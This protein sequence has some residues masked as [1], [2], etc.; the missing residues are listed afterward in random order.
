MQVAFFV[1]LILCSLCATL[2]AE[3][4]AK[5]HEAESLLLRKLIKAYE[6]TASLHFPLRKGTLYSFDNSFDGSQNQCRRGGE[7]E[8]S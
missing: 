7:E 4:S 8:N 1:S 5:I 3:I 6:R 2:V